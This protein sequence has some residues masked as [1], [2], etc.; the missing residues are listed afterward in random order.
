VNQDP[1][2]N[3]LSERLKR[4]WWVPLT[5]VPLTLLLMLGLQDFVRNALAIPLSYMLWLLRILLETIPQLWCW[6]GL[7]G[8]VLVI[9]LRSLDREHR[10]PS[11]PPGSQTRLP[12]GH[13]DMWATRIT[14][15]LQGKYSRHR[16][17][18]FIGKLILDVL[19]HEERLN[20]REVERRIEQNAFD[21]PPAARDYL[22]AR[23]KPGLSEAP[24]GFLKWLKRLLRLE[25]PPSVYLNTELETIVTFLED[26]MEV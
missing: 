2:E 22:Y 6:T 18:Y 1:P 5:G 12:P 8:V 3:T 7:L 25:Q 26:Q 19:S 24:S 21:L 15:L 23:L 4:F 13:I 14:M 16:F 10:P 11:T 17:G 20:Y 9:A